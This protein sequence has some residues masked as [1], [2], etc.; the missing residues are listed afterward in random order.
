MS[1]SFSFSKYIM[2]LPISQAL[3]S[4]LIKFFFKSTTYFSKSEGKFC[5][6]KSLLLISKP[7]LKPQIFRSWEQILNCQSACQKRRQFTLGEMKIANKRGEKI[8]LTTSYKIQ[9]KTTITMLCY[10][11]LQNKEKWKTQCWWFFREI[12]RY[13]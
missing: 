13:C 7:G 8:D 5:L 3:D 11:Y 12:F 9:I 4:L 1:F 6:W 10:T 2:V